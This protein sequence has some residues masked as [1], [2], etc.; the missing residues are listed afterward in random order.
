MYKS[1]IMK[2]D[3]SDIIIKEI[4]NKINKRIKK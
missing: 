2:D 3:E 1:V 4:E